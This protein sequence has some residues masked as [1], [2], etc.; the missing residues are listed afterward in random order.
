M[1]LGKLKLKCESCIK[2]S[3]VLSFNY[4][5]FELTLLITIQIFLTNVLQEL[6]RA[7]PASRQ[8]QL[9]YCVLV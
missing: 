2:S 9:S 6:K 4:D 1:S 3:G 5:N 8:I 7:V